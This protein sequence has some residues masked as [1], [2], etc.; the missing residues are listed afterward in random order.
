LDPEAGPEAVATV[1]ISTI[2]GAVMMS[3]LYRDIDYVHRAVN[4]LMRYLGSLVR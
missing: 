4:H 1:M 3:K 2:E